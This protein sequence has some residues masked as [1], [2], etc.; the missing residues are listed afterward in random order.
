MTQKGQTVSFVALFVAIFIWGFAY[1]VT[2]S[3]LSA[4]PPMLFALL[5]YSVASLL[6]VPLALAR[7]GLGRLPHPIPW[8]TLVLMALTGVGVYYILFNLSLSYTTASQTALIQSSFPA[9]VAIMAVVWLRE[10]VTRRRMTGIALAV[11]GVVLIV[12]STPTD[13]T[14]RDPLLGSTLA[15]AS[16]LSWGAYTILAKRMATAD[17]IAVTAT[18]SL[19]GMILLVPAVLVEGAR[20]SLSSIPASGWVPILYLG[21]LA[22]AASYLLYMRA[23]REIDASLVGA[24]INLSPV[25]GVVAGVV[26]L[27]EAITGPSIL[28]G[29]MVL[30]GVWMSSRQSA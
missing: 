10:R 8:K 14:A 5:R 28:G 6:L 23:L 19:I 29:V 22:S 9:V 24:F 7:G 2:K 4:V 17:P 26:V 27:G 13:A 21:A 3:G 16:V 25:I 1:V 15:F 18:I 20:I 12:A 11:I 30:A